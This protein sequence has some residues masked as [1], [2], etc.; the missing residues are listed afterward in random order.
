MSLTSMDDEIPYTYNSSKQLH[1]I[2]LH[3][4]NNN[5]LWTDNKLNIRQALM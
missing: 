1:K 5:I 2:G 3:N 4:N